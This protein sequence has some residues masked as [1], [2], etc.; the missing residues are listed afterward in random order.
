[1]SDAPARAPL[2]LAA[3]RVGDLG[4]RAGRW[5]AASRPRQ[6]AALI[7]LCLALYL[8]GIA[9]LPVTDRDEARFAQATKQML[10][11]GDLIDIR[12][13]DVPRSCRRGWKSSALN[14]GASSALRS[15][16]TAARALLG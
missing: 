6:A 16:C 10:T 4:R 3:E 8:P 11:S 5:L 1:M 7:L 13:Q 2:S 14:S 12:F 9:A 15:T